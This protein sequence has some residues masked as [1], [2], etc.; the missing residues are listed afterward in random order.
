MPHDESKQAD[1]CAA[2]RLKLLSYLVN[3]REVLLCDAMRIL[4][5]RDRAEDVVQDAAIRCM[6]SRAIADQINSPRGFVRRMVQNLALDQCRRSAR[7]KIVVLEPG[8]EL[9]CSRPNTERQME[10][11]EDLARVVSQMD[12]LPP[13]HRR[14]FLSHRI[15]DCLQKD[16][17]RR[18]GLSPARING[19]IAQTQ[20]QLLA[21]L[22]DDPAPLA[23]AAE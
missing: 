16:V 4:G 7:E 1:A 13:Q 2:A 18:F 17:A 22:Q 6:E 14:I 3:E 20:T 15:D 12:N 21:A 5:S 10:A 19:I 23:I 8:E 9:P 11:K